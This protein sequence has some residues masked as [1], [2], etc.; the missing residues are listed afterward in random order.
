METLLPSPPKSMASHGAGSGF[1][2]QQ[3]GRG[4]LGQGE[5]GRNL[6]D[7]KF[8]NSA[9]PG[10][11]CLLSECQCVELISCSANFNSAKFASDS[12][13][14]PISIQYLGITMT[15]LGSFSI[16]LIFWRPGGFLLLLLL[17]WCLRL[18]DDPLGQR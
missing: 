10:R 4:E 6:L 3:F 1:P 11:L 15:F 16:T 13:L 5:L 9:Y 17:P 2:S 12:Y 8:V 18:A 7:P 14:C